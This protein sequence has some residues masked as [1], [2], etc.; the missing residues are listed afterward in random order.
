MQ[1]GDYGNLL[2]ICGM[3][4]RTTPAHWLPILILMLLAT[5]QNVFSQSQDEWAARGYSYMERD[6]LPQAEECF[7]EAIEADPESVRNTMLLTNLGTIQRR[8][9]KMHEAIES[10]TKALERSP[11]DISALMNRATV[12][13][14]LG[15]DDKAYTDLC[16]VLNKDK[17]HTEALYYR[18][19]IYT[20]RREYAAARTDYKRLLDADP[21]HANGLF[22]LAILDQLEGRLQA[23]EQQLSRLIDRYPDNTTYWQARANVLKESGLYDLALIDLETAITLSPTDAYLYVDRAELYLKLKRHTA[24]KHDLNCAVALGIPRNALS[25]FYE[26]C[27]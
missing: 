16:N 24:A 21:S 23:A 25:E 12:Y 6:S 22:G 14:A 1:F 8:R 11:M 10:Y 13:M 5:T 26:Q 27:K 17:F 4:K 2:Y 3:N 20:H 15:N 9:G 7:R 18:A 19:F